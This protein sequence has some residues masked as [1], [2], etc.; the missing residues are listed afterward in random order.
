MIIYRVEHKDTGL[1]PYNH[2]WDEEN[3]ELEDKLQTEHSNLSHPSM[4][5]DFDIDM[6]S[7]DH[8]FGFPSLTSLAEWF[9]G[10]WI[11]ILIE[12]GFIIREYNVDNVLMG[13]SGRQVMFKKKENELCLN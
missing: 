5:E 11:G 12:C 6:I 1:G 8:Y 4:Y 7:R 3:A 9:E 10:G 2:S 13:K